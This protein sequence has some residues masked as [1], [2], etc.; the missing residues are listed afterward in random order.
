MI[1]PGFQ[2][3]LQLAHRRLHGKTKHKIYKAAGNKEQLWLPL[4]RAWQEER[5]KQKSDIQIWKIFGSAK[6]K[7][8]ATSWCKNDPWSLLQERKKSHSL[9]GQSH[10]SEVC[11]QLTCTGQGCSLG[12]GEKPYHCL[13]FK[14]SHSFKKVLSMA[15]PAQAISTPWCLSR[16]G[17]RTSCVLVMQDTS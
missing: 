2:L 11:M 15:A 9:K 12:D 4:L 16:P 13:F 7:E 6:E 5:R 14:L 17:A 1:F 3:L 10:V 8:K